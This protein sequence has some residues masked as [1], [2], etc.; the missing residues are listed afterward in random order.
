MEITIIN[1][2]EK[3]D[4]DPALEATVAKA[5]RK[6]AEIHGVPPQT[7][8]SLVLV[9]DEEISALNREYRDIDAPTDVLSFALTE[10]GSDEPEYEVPLEMEEVLGDIVISLETAQRQATEYGHGLVRETAYLA[11][12]GM[13][14]LLGYDHEDEDER[15]RMRAMEERVLAEIGLGRP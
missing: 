10:R 8:V 12:H 14:H 9:D 1:R 15:K 11:V 5:L 2:Q 7:E 13:L 6:T 3:V 4:W